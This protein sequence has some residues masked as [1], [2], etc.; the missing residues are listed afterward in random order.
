M[1]KCVLLIVCLFVALLSVQAARPRA[2]HEPGVWIAGG[3]HGLLLP[4]G[5]DKR[6]LNGYEASLGF[7][8]CLSFRRF[9]FH[10]G[11]GGC[12]ARVNSKGGNASVALPNSVDAD[13]YVFTF[14]YDLTARSDR[15]TSI[16][17]QVPLM[18]G[19]QFDR[20]YFLLGTKFALTAMAQSTTSLNV[21]SY[22]DYPQFLDPFTG[23][24]EHQYFDATAKKATSEV[25]FA[26]DIKGAV[27]IGAQVIKPEENGQPSLR[28]AL[29][30][31]MSILNI[32]TSTR[33]QAPVDHPSTFTDTDMLTPVT[34]NPYL[35]TTLVGN[36]DIRRLAAGVKVV[37]SFPYTPKKC[38]PCR[39]I[40]D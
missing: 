17:V 36:G 11:I 3:Y 28:I 2:T 22:G 6:L 38:Y 4:S 12:L 33:R 29:Y 20:F 21:S 24:P 14:V 13:G 18:V 7:D 25:S 35:S 37:L 27:E 5:S 34:P 9:L 15:Y 30:A 1:R 40:R 31:D 16:S 23:M 32:M 19:A 26:P 8:Y 39:W 10:T